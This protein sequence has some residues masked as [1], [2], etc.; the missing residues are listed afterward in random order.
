VLCKEKGIPCIEVD[1]KQKLGISVGINVSTSSVA[2]VES[3]DASKDIA[4]IKE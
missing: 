3:G 4:Q 1:S 2:V